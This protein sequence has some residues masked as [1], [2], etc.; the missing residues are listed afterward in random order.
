M[1]LQISGRLSSHR[2]AFAALVAAVSGRCTSMLRKGWS[3][4][5]AMEAIP[6]LGDLW[7]AGPDPDKQNMSKI[8][9]ETGTEGCQLGG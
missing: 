9:K 3:M 8:Q 6:L 5:E 2:L 1:A 7:Q 4:D